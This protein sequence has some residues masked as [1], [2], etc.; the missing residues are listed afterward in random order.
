M[1]HMHFGAGRLGL[2][3]VVPAFQA[4]P[5]TSVILNRAV[6]GANATGST[7]LGAARRNTLL[8]DHPESAYHLQILDGTEARTE[9]IRYA[10]F[11]TYEGGDVAA[12][13]RAIAAASEA[14]RLELPWL[15]KPSLCGWVDDRVGRAAYGTLP[16]AAEWPGWAQSRMS[17]FRSGAKAR[18]WP[19]AE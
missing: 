7:A 8:R 14:D 4:S 15:H 12:Q 11:H 17:A 6:A 5:T 13:T 16:K 9:R 2:G 3:L 1:L 18:S 10:S 19:E